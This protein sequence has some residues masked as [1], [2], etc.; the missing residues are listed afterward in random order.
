M[1]LSP[2]SA[3]MIILS[4]SFA[5]SYAAVHSSFD[6]FCLVGLRFSKSFILSISV[7]T[8]FL[9]L[10]AIAGSIFAVFIKDSVVSIILNRQFFPGRSEFET[11][12]EDPFFLV[13]QFL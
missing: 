4:W 13:R 9:S 6:I 7:T 1:D 12:G 5:I 2:L 10:V 11:S 8:V 3:G